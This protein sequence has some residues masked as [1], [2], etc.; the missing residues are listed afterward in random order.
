MQEKDSKY[1]FHTEKRK[2]HNLKIQ[3]LALKLSG[4]SIK[5]NSGVTFSDISDRYTLVR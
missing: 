2:M 4:S 5:R 1:S 3:D